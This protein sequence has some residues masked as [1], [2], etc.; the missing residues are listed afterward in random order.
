M[1]I[2]KRFFDFYIDGSIH[3]ALSVYALV[4]ATLLFFDLGYDEAVAYIAFYGTIA[5]Y[6]FIKYD[7]LTRQNKQSIRKYHLVIL[8]ISLISLL[9]A[10]WYF[11]QL[12]R[13]TQFVTLFFGLLTL[14]Y[15]L[16]FLPKKSNARNWSGLK[17]Y[18]VCICWT[19]V[20]V[21]LPI[22]NSETEI[23]VAVVIHLVQRFIFVFVLMLI[24]EISDLEKDEKDLQTIPQQLGISQTK[25][26]GY[27]LLVGYLLLDFFSSNSNVKFQLVTLLLVFAIAIFLF[28][29]TPKRSKYYTAF[30]VE[31]IPIL[32]LMMIVSCP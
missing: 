10:G 4:R 29:V 31:A 22:L 6:N 18:L 9:L 19:G 26:L 2:L 1:R 15:T 16:P 21:L 14:F 3:V 23:N 13:Q 25:W 20:T 32:W 30:W 5:G 8:G 7:E 17:I 12:K 28:F 27:G 24:F 11:F